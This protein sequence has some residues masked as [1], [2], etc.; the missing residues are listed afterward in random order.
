MMEPSFRHFNKAF[1]R[2]SV[3]CGIHYPKDVPESGFTG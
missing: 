1:H 2:F 3:C